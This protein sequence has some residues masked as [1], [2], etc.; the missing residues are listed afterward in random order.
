MCQALRHISHANGC[1]LVFASVKENKGSSL[2]RSLLNYFCFE[3]GTLAKADKN[4]NNMIHMPAGSDK[5]TD[6]GEPE[7]A[8]QRNLSFDQ[9]WKVL[10]E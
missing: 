1:D 5:F 9:L 7:G 4:P 10:I 2:Y 3:D 6:I 8:S